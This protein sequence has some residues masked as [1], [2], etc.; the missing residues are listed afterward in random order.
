[1]IVMI[2]FWLLKIKSISA[3]NYDSIFSTV[4]FISSHT[5]K[6]DGKGLKDYIP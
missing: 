5:R 1:M 6:A 3:L 4:P 2:I